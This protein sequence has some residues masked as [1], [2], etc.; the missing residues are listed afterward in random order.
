MHNGVTTLTCRS[1]SKHHYVTSVNE[2]GTENDNGD[3]NKNDSNNGNQIS[4]K[5]LLPYTPYTFSCRR[6]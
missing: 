1:A 3:D 2:G 4:R 5:T 6:Q